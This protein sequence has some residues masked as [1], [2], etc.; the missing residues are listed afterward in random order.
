MLC[1]RVG[2]AYRVLTGTT[3]NRIWIPYTQAP[4][5][6]W[7]AS[8]YTLKRCLSLQAVCGACKLVLASKASLSCSVHKKRESSR[9]KTMLSL[10]C[11]VWCLRVGHPYRG[12]IVRLRSIRNGSCRSTLSQKQKAP[13]LRAK[14]P[15]L[16]YKNQSPPLRSIL[17]LA[18]KKRSHQT[19]F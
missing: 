8:C 4:H 7:K 12:P 3:L 11:G 6:A 13:P 1:V 9:T 14:K 5:T 16:T 2:H 17:T 18:C 15:T 19:S 10:T